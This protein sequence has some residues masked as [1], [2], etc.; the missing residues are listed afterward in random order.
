MEALKPACLGVRIVTR[1][2][3]NEPKPVCRDVP[4]V[5]R[6]RSASTTYMEHPTTAGVDGEERAFTHLPGWAVCVD[7]AACCLSHKTGPSES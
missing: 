1:D 3:P 7:L 6:T 2:L 5:A 4:P